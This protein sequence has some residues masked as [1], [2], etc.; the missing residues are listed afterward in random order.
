MNRDNDREIE[1]YFGMQTL[2]V[3][4]RKPHD[5]PSSVYEYDALPKEVIDRLKELANS[6]HQ[7][8][9]GRQCCF[10]EVVN[11][12]GELEIHRGISPRSPEAMRL[13]EAGV[14]IVW[15]EE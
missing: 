2:V 5:N 12:E 9:S 4:E 14:P 15:E 11:I 10:P 6:G 1:P 7:V 13:Q 3:V 8:I